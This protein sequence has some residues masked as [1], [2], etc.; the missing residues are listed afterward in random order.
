MTEQSTRKTALVTGGTDGIGK[1]IARS[2]AAQG[3]R[4]GIVGRDAVKG[5]TAE[6]ELRTST[7]NPHIDFHQADISLMSECH[8]LSAEI[9]NR[10]TALHYLVHNAGVIRGRRELTAEGI[11]VTF[12]TNY[13]SRYA[14]TQRL[15]PL[16]S[17][18]GTPEEPARIVCVSGAAQHGK[19]YFDDVNL[20][21]N[22]SLVRSVLQF[23][24][25]NDLYT[26][27]LTH[28]LRADGHAP[29]IVVTCLKV[30][31]VR[32]E[33]R[34]GLPLWMKVLVPLVMDPL[35]GQTPQDV[36]EATMTLLVGTEAQ[37]V[38]GRLFFK[39]RRLNQAPALAPDNAREQR[40]RLWDLSERLAFP[41]PTS[42][43]SGAMAHNSVAQGASG[44]DRG[45]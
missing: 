31:V 7:R 20:T 8:R 11:E 33:I 27:E 29:R 25:A 4:V 15:M 23:C 45:P 13:L 3:M 30:G 28:R 21:S 6:Q 35:L 14:L 38:A 24:E 41:A 2:L 36:A 19:I 9:L 34:R 32:T 18:T 10:W 5:R 42:A 43:P 40:K 22:F 17:A 26:A 44:A 1:E 37:D 12:A 39:I 16:L